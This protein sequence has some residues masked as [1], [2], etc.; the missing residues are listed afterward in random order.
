MKLTNDV[1][2][3]G[4]GN[5]GFNLSDAGDC[6]IY[7]VNGGS[8]YA[9]ID[10]GTGAGLDQVINNVRADGLDPGR[11][12]HL[13]VTHYHTDHAGGLA[14]AREMTGARTYAST[15]CAPAIETADEDAIGL[16]H[17]K[18]G[19]FYPPD[20]RFE[21]CPINVRY[22][23]DDSI[24][25]GDLKLVALETPGHCAGHASLLLQG[26]DRTYLFSGDSL[27][28]GGTIILQNLPDC[29]LQD[30]VASIN[31]LALV[32]FDALLP[33]HLTLS[34]NDGRRHADAAATTVRSLGIPKQAISF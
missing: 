30:T 22:R 5:L 29:S 13:I 17:A 33:G 15:G 23:E 8:E 14:Q 21:P 11:I 1:Y 34:L 3:V 10:V 28:W 6:H 24:T 26:K 18:A 2:L 27:F 9:L 19:G 20:Y 32:E 12:N 7:L 16:A 31:K 25:V 4:G